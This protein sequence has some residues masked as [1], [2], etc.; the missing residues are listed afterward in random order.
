MMTINAN[1]RIASLLKGHPGALE[2][3]VSI[4]PKFAKLRNPILRKV[5]AARTSIAMASKLGGCSIDD[6]FRKLAPL[7]FEIDRTALVKEREHTTAPAFVELAAGKIIE[8]DVRPVME[9]G[10]DPLDIIV[11]RIKTLPEGYVL[12]IVNSFEPVPLMRLLGKQGFESYAEII[13]DELVNTY[14]HKRTEQHTI[15]ANKNPGYS[16]DWD[17]ILIR[18]KDRLETIDVTSLE[19]PLPMHRILE[20]LKTLP[21]DKALFV[22]HKR[23]PVYLLPELEEQG[24]SYRIKEIGDAEV[25]LL[26]YKN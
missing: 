24:F 8:L 12:K 18:F 11:E 2:A 22:V 3:I 17:Q 7:G 20:S 25:H 23:I 4:S 26:I 5:I 13:S 19:M 10:K 6:F 16:V 15:A 9:T 14:F 1:T 21:G